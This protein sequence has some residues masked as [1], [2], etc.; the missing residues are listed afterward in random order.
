MYSC[1]IVVVHVF[2]HVFVVKRICSTVEIINTTKFWPVFCK[3]L[4]K[5]I[6]MYIQ[7]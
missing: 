5:Y 1:I 4:W 7:T 6:L 2:E 3:K